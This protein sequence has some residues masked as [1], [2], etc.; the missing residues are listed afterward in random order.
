MRVL[1]LDLE[2][3][4][5]AKLVIFLTDTIDGL[6]YSCIFVYISH[7]KDGEN[8]RDNGKML[9]R[10]ATPSD[11]TLKLIKPIA[12]VERSKARTVFTRSNTAIVG[13]NPT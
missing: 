11:A 7:N 2:E 5:I 4:L 9:S 1:Q 3:V 13:S 10:T 6:I 8:T 12:V